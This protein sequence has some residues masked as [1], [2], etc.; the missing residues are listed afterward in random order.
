LENNFCKYR[1]NRPRQ[2]FFQF[3]EINIFNKNYELVLFEA[4]L[5]EVT[6]LTAN[7]NT[8]GRYIIFVL[9]KMPKH[10]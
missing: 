2:Y 3:I 4:D 9:T 5:N 6:I 7:I 1:E 10:E 8:N